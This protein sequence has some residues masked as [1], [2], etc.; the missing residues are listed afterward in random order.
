MSLAMQSLA[1]QSLG[2]KLPSKSHSWW[3]L[4][5]AQHVML[6]VLFVTIH[7]CTVLHFARFGCISVGVLLIRIPMVEGIQIC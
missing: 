3:R 6:K 7:R 4:Q 5:E 2:M 1:A